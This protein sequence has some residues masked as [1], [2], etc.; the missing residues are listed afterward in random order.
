M[1]TICSI[2]GL[3]LL[4][5]SLGTCRQTWRA[6][7]NESAA[8][9][10]RTRNETLLSKNKNNMANTLCNGRGMLIGFEASKSAPNHFSI[11]KAQFVSRSWLR[12][13]TETANSYFARHDSLPLFRWL[14]RFSTHLTAPLHTLAYPRMCHSKNLISVMTATQK[15]RSHLEI[16]IDV[17]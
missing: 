9:A 10:H 13:H 17:L 1:R 4:G 15:I 5:P 14:R 8:V 6:R 7:T 16:K 12:S 2:V 11:R 3:A